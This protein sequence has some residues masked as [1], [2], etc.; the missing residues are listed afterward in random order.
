MDADYLPTA[1]A[2]QSYVLVYWGNNQGRF[3]EVFKDYGTVHL[4]VLEKVLADEAEIS[5]ENF[6][7][8]EVPFS[9][10]K[11]LE[12]TEAPETT[13]IVVSSSSGSLYRYLKNN[14]LKSGVVASYPRVQGA[15]DP[16]NV[17]HWYWGYSYK[18]L[19]SGSWKS[20]SISVSRQK[21]H[22]VRQMIESNTPVAVIKDFIKV[23]ADESKISRE[24]VL[25][26]ETRF[27]RL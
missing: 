24:K 16:D 20:K 1:P 11:N 18:V 7:V 4:P 13:Y 27:S 26:D 22:A 14:K 23:L 21:V 19:R 12:L 9:L 10:E 17:N 2:Q 5:R 15:R 6:L 25:A 3:R 8:D